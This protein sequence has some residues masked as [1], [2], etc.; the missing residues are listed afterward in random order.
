[1]SGIEI[2]H[3]IPVYITDGDSAM[4][5]YDPE[6]KCY[7]HIVVKSGVVSRSVSGRMGGPFYEH[8]EPFPN[9]PKITI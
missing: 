4:S 6:L 3:A 1:M 8:Q 7:C 2:G 9:E 5:W